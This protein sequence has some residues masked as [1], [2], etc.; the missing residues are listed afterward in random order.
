MMSS[1]NTRQI[2]A[3]MIFYVILSCHLWLGESL[4]FHP[5]PLTT[6]T[7]ASRS[8]RP[9]SSRLEMLPG[10]GNQLA[11]AYN[12]ATCEKEEVEY[13]RMVPRRQEEEEVQEQEK[14]QDNTSHWRAVAS[15][16]SFLTRVFHKPAVADNQKNTNTNDDDQQQQQQRQKPRFTFPFTNFLRNLNQHHHEVEEAKAAASAVYYPIVGF[17]FVKGCEDALP[18]TSHASIPMP[19]TSQKK[20]DVYGWY[21]TACKLDLYSEDVCHD[22][23]EH[24]QQQQTNTNNDE[25]I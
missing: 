6:S 24:Q 15:S 8:P 11:A 20:Q 18:T 13:G 17:K 10:Q 14:E 21:S 4:S 25:M 23:I 1:K 22:P 19:T 9:S 16:K 7:I 5:Q 3:V 12:A 2:E